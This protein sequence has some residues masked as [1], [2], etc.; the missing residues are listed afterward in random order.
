MNKVYIETYGCQMNL[1]DTEIVS[2]ILNENGYEI[3]NDIKQAN[4]ILLNTCSVRENAERK[5][6]EKLIHLQQYKKRKSNLVVGVIGCMAERLQEQISND[7]KIVNLIVGPDEYRKLPYLIENSALGKVGIAVELNNFEIYDDI[8][9]LR[10]NGISAWLSIMRGCNNFCS[11]CVVP[12]TR[13]RERSRDFDSI[14]QEIKDLNSKGFKE[15]TLLGQ[16]VNSYK[17]NNHGFPELIEAAAISAPIMR[18]RFITSH[19]KDMSDELIIK[20]SEHKNIC[21]YIHLPVQS[22][23]NRI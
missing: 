10:T 13:G 23:S 19:P 9:P 4:V 6:F 2:S 12:S 1:N 14:I 5:I 18:I 15:V 3:V 20:M 22:G 8:E 7:R 11:Y 21:K 17:S 16:N